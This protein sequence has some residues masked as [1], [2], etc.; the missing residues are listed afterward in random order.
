MSSFK[1]T[2]KPVNNSEKD[3][4]TNNRGSFCPIMSGNFNDRLDCDVDHCEWGN[5]EGLCIVWDFLKIMREFPR[6]RT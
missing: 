1:K 3:G 6:A 2:L 5:G 4:V